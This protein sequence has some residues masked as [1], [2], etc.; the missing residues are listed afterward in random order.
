MDNGNTRKPLPDRDGSVILYEMVYVFHIRGVVFY[1]R[2]FGKRF[3]YNSV[4]IV[5]RG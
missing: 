2:C 4:L 1:T 5:M 3:A